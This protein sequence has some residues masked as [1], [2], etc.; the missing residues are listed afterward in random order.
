[1]GMMV[2]N[3][4]GDQKLEAFSGGY[5]YNFKVS[6]V[7]LGKFNLGRADVVRSPDLGPSAGWSG[8]STL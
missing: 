6:Y 2:M 7:Q 4:K 3:G 8:S 5:N 1:M